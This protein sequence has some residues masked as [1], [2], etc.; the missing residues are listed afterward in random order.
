MQHF[1]GR[2]IITQVKGKRPEQTEFV[3]TQV[4]TTG[5]QLQIF[6]NEKYN[7]VGVPGATIENYNEKLDL[8]PE[9]IK[10][11][12]KERGGGDE[13]TGIGVR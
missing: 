3:A 7:V 12:V 8:L 9:N 10:N 1:L 5:L 13:R 11:R 6:P 4:Q 2:E